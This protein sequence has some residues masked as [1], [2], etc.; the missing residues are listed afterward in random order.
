MHLSKARQLSGRC[1]GFILLT[2]ISAVLLFAP[3]AKGQ[4]KADLSRLV[5]VGDSL[6]AGF[7]NYSL[8]ELQQPKGYAS[9]V[10]AQA[11]MQLSLPL[12]AAPGIPNVLELKHKGPPPVIVP[13][14]GISTG[15]IQPMV[16]PF[17]LAVPGAKVKD[18][19]LARPEWPIATL[20]DLVLG[21]PGLIEGD[22]PRSQVER[23]ER[24]KPET[25]ILWIGSNDI[26]D[27]SALKAS[28]AG[29]TNPLAFTLYHAGVVKR[30]AATGAKLIVGNIPD[31]TMIA[32][33][34]PAEAVAQQVGLP[35]AVIGPILG[36]SPGTF[37][38]TSELGRIPAILSNPKE[39]PLN[40]DFVLDRQEVIKIR[41]ATRAYNLAIAIQARLAGAAVADI[42]GLVA[43]IHQQG[44]TV[45]SQ[46][47]TTAYF[48]GLFSLDGVHPTNTGYAII[49]NEFIKAMNQRFST[50]IEYASVADV[51]ATDPLVFPAVSNPVSSL[52]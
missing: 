33:F 2:C 1:A 35:L 40:K 48:G 24:L 20:T 3:S 12:I 37:V 7:Q 13:A 32:A 41:A 38:L 45:G 11:K 5:V 18:A 47:L 4:K 42:H 8:H 23:A 51:M 49:A 9:V 52:R 17:N 16:Q 44:Y 39:G 27:F 25:I 29:I 6:S 22:A 31:V 26:L 34:T 43:S 19:L 36:I 46:H 28:A 14:P 10:A 21:L 30:L 15:R 50:N